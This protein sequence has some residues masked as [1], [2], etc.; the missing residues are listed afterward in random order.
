MT[1]LM[2]VGISVGI[3]AGLWTAASVSFGLVTFAGFLSWASFYAAGGKLNGL[4]TS[5]ILNFSGV[6]WGYLIVLV[7]GLLGP[8]IGATVGLGLAVALGA[9]GMCWQAK[10]SW[11]GFIPGAFIGCSAFFAT[12]FDFTGAVIGLICGAVLGY[13]S[14]AMALAMQKKE[15]AE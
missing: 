4:K 15:I 13:I 6:I 5:L 2:A 12:N 10:I 7:A 11:L 1:F 9:A 8:M 14:E 3:L